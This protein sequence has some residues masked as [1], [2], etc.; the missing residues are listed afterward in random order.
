M[1]LLKDVMGLEGT[2]T[3]EMI[4]T[5]TDIKFLSE[6]EDRIR[7]IKNFVVQEDIR[8]IKNLLENKD[9]IK[10]MEDINSI[11]TKRFGF[12]ITLINRNR[13]GLSTIPV[14]PPNYNVL[15]GSSLD[16]IKALK[17]YFTNPKNATKIYKSNSSIKDYDASVDDVYNSIYKSY[18]SLKESLDKNKVVI[19]LKN[20]R[21]ENLP[22]EY[23][24]F[25]FI[26]ICYALHNKG[27][28]R[29][30]EDLMAGILHEIGHTFTSFEKSIYSVYNTMVLL[31]TIREVK[32]SK[33]NDIVNIIEITN[34]RLGI[35]SSQKGDT[36]SALVALKDSL[37]G[38]VFTDDKT[39]QNSRISAE[40]QADQFANRFG[41]GKQSMIGLSTYGTFFR[42]MGSVE[43]SY[44]SSKVG[45]VLILMLMLVYFPIGIPLI[46]TM[47]LSDITEIRDYHRYNKAYDDDIRRTLRFKQDAIRQIRL[48]DGKTIDK[49][50]IKR[51]EDTIEFADAK[52]QI[53]SNPDNKTFITKFYDKYQYDST[54]KKVVNML[55][56]SESLMENDLHYINLKLKE[57]L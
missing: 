49:D 6:V 17:E 8:N 45:A 50:I 33:E 57:R 55:E 3:H 30:P 1:S 35:K 24:V 43:A 16:F 2:L 28:N 7:S 48:L 47:I 21:I 53:L 13:S 5:Q 11:L 42:M 36:I 9:I 38:Y 22:K 27:Q 29:S 54:T 34:N 15:N 46:I 23:N 56:I 25:I 52:I 12:S 14:Y 18:K 32:N 19:D 26:D 39:L 20:A 51:L 10:H 31:D 41:Y 37:D 44:E 4:H 40:Q